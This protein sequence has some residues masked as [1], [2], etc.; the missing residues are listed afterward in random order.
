M[1]ANPRFPRIVSRLA[2]ALTA[3]C[4]AACSTG[5]REISAFPL[6][7]LPGPEPSQSQDADACDEEGSLREC[8]EK[9]G[10]QKGFVSC[11]R[12]VQECRGGVWSRCGHGNVTFVTRQLSAGLGSGISTAISGAEPGRCA[13]EPCN[14]DCMAFDEKPL[15]PV[16]SPVLPGFSYEG[17]P[18]EWGNAPEGFVNKQNCGD[19]GG[20]SGCWSGYAKDCGG[21]P[22]HFNRF[23]GCQADHHCDQ[24]TNK[25]IRSMPGWTWPE[26]V[27][28]GV[29][30]AIGPSCHNG[31]DIGFPLCNRGNSDLPANTSIRIVLRNGN[32]YDFSCPRNPS[33]TNCN[34]KTSDILRPGECV[35]VVRGPSCNWNGNTVA[36]VNADK[37]VAECGLNQTLASATQPGCSNNWS[38]VTTGAVCET[39]TEYNYETTVIEE[40]YQAVCPKG[41]RPSW[42]VLLYDAVTPCSPGA[43]NGTNASSVKFEAQ[44]AP[45]SAPTNFSAWTTIAHAPAPPYTHPSSCTREGMAPCPVSL[46]SGLANAEDELLRIRVTV[47]PSPDGQA[48]ASLS[49]WQ[50]TY[51]CGAVE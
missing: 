18:N 15:E 29:D 42:G 39:Y 4:L 5:D 22:T 50:I 16:S 23:D 6:P 12:G 9:V 21:D 27:C 49:R 44:T 38:D 7:D 19:H 40:A 20:A 14:P 46:F 36:Y 32:N 25:C 45:A 48:G 1:A 17:N 8:S 47:S 43:C 34:I 3:A 11:M 51:N 28:P 31:K 37:S 10:E 2:L 35:R 30:L 33:G 13:A 24:A 26:S 41:A